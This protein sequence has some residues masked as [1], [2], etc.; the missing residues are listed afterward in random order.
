MAG[1]EGA[2]VGWVGKA[3]EFALYPK[4]NGKPSEEDFSGCCGDRELVD[5]RLGSGK[6]LEGGGRGTKVVAQ[7]RGTIKGRGK[8]CEFIYEDRSRCQGCGRDG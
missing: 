4:G 5:G 8:G 3:Q 2:E 1:R 7:I 6:C